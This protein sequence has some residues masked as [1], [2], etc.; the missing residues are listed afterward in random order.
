M[1]FVLF[2]RPARGFEAC[3]HLHPPQ[4]AGGEK[5]NER[6]PLTAG[7]GA[8]QAKIGDLGLSRGIVVDGETGEDGG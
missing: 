8:F 3:E 4:V 7:I 2:G 6:Q 5:R 1:V